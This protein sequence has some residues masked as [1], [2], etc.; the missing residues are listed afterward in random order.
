MFDSSYHKPFHIAGSPSVFLDLDTFVYITVLALFSWL[1]VRGIQKKKGKDKIG[2][3][4]FVSRYMLICSGVVFLAYLVNLLLFGKMVLSN[5]IICF[6]PLLYGGIIQLIAF[7]AVKTKKGQINKKIVIPVAIVILLLIWYHLPVNLSYHYAA[8]DSSEKTVKV[9]VYGKVFK[10][11]IGNSR[12]E[13]IV[14]IPSS[15]I[16]TIELNV[17]ENDFASED[18]THKSKAPEDL[19]YYQTETIDGITYRLRI[20]AN[21]SVIEYEEYNSNGYSYSLRKTG[22]WID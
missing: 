5:W 17:S 12:K 1:I 11:L 4:M 19:F 10:K 18:L 6:L 14:S 21:Q 13:F 8:V 7:I 2:L 3:A 9:D 20:N 15:R 22:R 16:R